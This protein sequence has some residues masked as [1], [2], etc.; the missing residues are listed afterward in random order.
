MVKLYQNTAKQSCS[1]K[2][3][4]LIFNCRPVKNMTLK[5]FKG[6]KSGSVTFLKDN[7]LYL[8]TWKKSRQTPCVNLLQIKFKAHPHKYF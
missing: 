8:H 7:L 5:I 1:S 4:S 3:T 6:N 2:E